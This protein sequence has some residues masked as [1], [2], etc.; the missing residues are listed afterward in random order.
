[1]LDRV[2]AGEDRL[3]GGVVAVAVRRHLLA[4]PVGLV[5]QGLHL[6]GGELR[7]V[8]L[9]GQRQHAPRG[10][11]LDHVGAVLD[12]EADRLAEPVRPVGD[13]LG[14]PELLDQ[15]S[16]RSPV[17]SACPPRAPS[18]WTAD[19]HPRAGDQ[20]AGDRIPQPHVEHV[21]APHV[22]HRGEP[23]LEHLPRVHRGLDRLL[24]QLAAEVVDELLLP[25]VGRLARQVGVRV[26][27][28]G[29]ERRVAQVDD[30]GAGGDG[31]VGPDGQ[32][33]R[34]LDQDDPVGLE[35][36]H[37]GLAV[38]QPRGLDGD[39]RRRLRLLGQGRGGCDQDNRGE[40][41]HR[42]HRSPRAPERDRAGRGH[43]VTARIAA[44]TGSDER[45]QP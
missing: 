36:I 16:W 31:Q 38:E 2:D 15:R 11:E 14:R 39:D 20:P 8:H 17:S 9:V 5:H 26:D 43:K 4:Q 28:A 24:G 29:R 21:A 18:A 44:R 33:L 6:L 7:R 23:G 12:L 30:L 13:P 25:V 32:D 3:A 10:A 19:Q 27:E 41:E 1:M 37:L 42:F 45:L 34:P 40:R 22:A 35:R